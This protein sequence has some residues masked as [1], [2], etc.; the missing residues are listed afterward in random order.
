M[1]AETRGMGTLSGWRQSNAM[2]GIPL[3]LRDVWAL[4]LIAFRTLTGYH[5]HRSKI[6][7]QFH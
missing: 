1:T 3:R 5:Y 7:S 6:N 4:G 2:E